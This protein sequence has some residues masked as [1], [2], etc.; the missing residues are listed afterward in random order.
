[1]WGEDII[2]G[3]GTHVSKLAYERT[4]AKLEELSKNEADFTVLAVSVRLHSSGVLKSL[5][6]DL[7]REYGFI[8]RKALR[9]EMELVILDSIDL[10]GNRYVLLDKRN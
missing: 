8:R 3:D 1:M 6:L 10:V 2:L 5:V 4:Y 9:K 7:F